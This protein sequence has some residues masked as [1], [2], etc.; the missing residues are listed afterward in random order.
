METKPSASAYNKRLEFKA[1]D[2]VNFKYFYSKDYKSLSEFFSR[3]DNVQFVI[4]IIDKT[5]VQPE[6]RESF[7][8]G[9]KENML[10]ELTL[11]EITNILKTL[12]D[13]S[14]SIGQVEYLADLTEQVLNENEFKNHIIEIDIDEEE[15]RI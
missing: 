6:Y 13:N 10:K 15:S 3:F 1:Y 5:T 11:N 4:E 8:N 7:I 2:H 14:L 9:V 12:I